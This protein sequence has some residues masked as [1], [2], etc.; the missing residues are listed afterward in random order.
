[1]TRLCAETMSSITVNSQSLPCSSSS[2][3]AVNVSYA[4]CKL[5]T[6]TDNCVVGEPTGII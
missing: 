6:H 3:S 4:W 2:T 5:Y 1:M